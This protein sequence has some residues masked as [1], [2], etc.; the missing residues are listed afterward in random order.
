MA[1]FRESISE[2]LFSLARYGILSQV[3]SRVEAAS[4]ITEAAWISQIRPNNPFGGQSGIYERAYRLVARI[5][6]SFGSMLAWAAK[7]ILKD[8]LQRMEQEQ[9]SLRKSL[10]T[11]VA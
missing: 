1:R 6:T 3:R 4:A 8:H 5:Q 10:Q 11:E 7:Y 9:D 2:T